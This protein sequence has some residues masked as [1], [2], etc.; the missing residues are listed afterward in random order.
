MADWDLSGIRKKVRQVTGRLTPEDLSNDQL[1]E[2][3]NRYYQFTFPAEL[4]L[5]K[6]HTY[7]EFLTTENQPFYDFADTSYTNVEPEATLNNLSL[8]WYQDPNAFFQE[9][10]LQYTMATP[11]TGDGVTVTFS[12]TVQGFP[13]FP[14]STIIYDGIEKFEDTNET[15]ASSPVTI[16]GDQGGTSTINYSTG[17]IS[18]TFNTAPVD[19]K[20]INLSY[21]L[22]Q[23]GRPTAVLFYDSKF[24]FF[25]VPDQAYKFRIK[26]YKVVDALVNATDTPDFE[27]WGPCIAY[28]A[29][30][31]IHSDYGE[32]EDYAQVTALYKEQLGYVLR[33]TNQNLLNTRSLPNF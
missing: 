6:K 27:E 32:Y 19:G 31:D 16:T 30:R 29:S 1:D 33:R 13:I 17:A 15:F 11:W 3:I 21:V 28:G 26:T 25:T 8:L 7:Y 9:N 10:P 5:D 18:V 24:Q 20:N 2:Y 22:F 12:T 23:A 4:K 14:G